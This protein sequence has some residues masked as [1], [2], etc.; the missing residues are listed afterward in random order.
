MPKHLRWYQ[1]SQVSHATLSDDLTAFWHWAQGHLMF[2]QGVLFFFSGHYQE[3]TDKYKGFLLMNFFC[4]SPM[5]CDPYQIQSRWVLAQYS[6]FIHSTCHH[7][8][9]WGWLQI[10]LCNHSPKTIYARIFG[11]AGHAILVDFRSVLSIIIGVSVSALSI[12]GGLSKF[13]FCILKRRKKLKAARNATALRHT[14]YTV[15]KIHTMLTF[16]QIHNPRASA[17]MTFQNISPIQLSRI[18]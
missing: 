1:Q 6:V 2:G 10:T 4:L 16:F 13:V 3:K 11:A 15:N 7:P 17:T 12:I 8:S 14:G 18:L 5:G 9:I